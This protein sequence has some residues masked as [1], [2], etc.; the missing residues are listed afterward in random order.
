MGPSWVPLHALSLN[1][2]P[3]DIHCGGCESRHGGESGEPEQNRI[4][5][6][7]FDS[8]TH[9]AGTFVEG[10]GRVG[11]GRWLRLALGLLPSHG[12]PVQP[13]PRKEFSPCVVRL[14]A[15]EQHARGGVW[16]AMTLGGEDPA[17]GT[18]LTYGYPERNRYS[19]RYGPCGTGPVPLCDKVNGEHQGDALQCQDS[20]SRVPL[21]ILV[22]G[23]Q[24]RTPLAALFL[25]QTATTPYITRNRDHPAR[26]KNDTIVI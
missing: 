15:A 16:A 2:K 8:H 17:P 22:C 10:A 1:K 23:R 19:C 25:D 12:P 4:A 18:H 14:A 7:S 5:S 11:D 21:R 6:A 26:P 24:Y 3:G 20:E 9:R 13:E